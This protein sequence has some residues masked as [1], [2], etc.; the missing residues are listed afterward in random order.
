MYSMVN[1]EFSFGFRCENCAENKIQMTSD[2]KYVTPVLGMGEYSKSL[3][4]GLSL[5]DTVERHC[6]FLR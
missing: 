6:V 2:F 4:Y 5:R 3:Y 1:N